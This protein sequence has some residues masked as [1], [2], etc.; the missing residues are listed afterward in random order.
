MSIVLR[1]PQ[2]R[3]FEGCHASPACPSDNSAIKM[4]MSVGHY[5]IAT[6]KQDRQCT[7]NV[8][9]GRLSVT[10]VAVE[11]YIPSVCACVCV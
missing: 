8:T 4:E 1:Y 3:F 6:G 9:L 5:W 2:G 11:K 10:V 7:Y